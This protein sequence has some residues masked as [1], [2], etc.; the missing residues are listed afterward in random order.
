M[1]VGGKSKLEFEFEGDLSLNVVISWL[2]YYV[3][4]YLLISIAMAT[5]LE[6]M[7]L[8]SLMWY[9]GVTNRG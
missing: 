5:L 4:E 2:L 1:R 3:L 6:Q 9:P 7:D 8:S